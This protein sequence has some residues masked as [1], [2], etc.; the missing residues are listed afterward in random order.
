LSEFS[1]LDALNQEKGLEISQGYYDGAKKR[2]DTIKAK[3]EE[4]LANV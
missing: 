2:R 3:L 1:Q 4:K